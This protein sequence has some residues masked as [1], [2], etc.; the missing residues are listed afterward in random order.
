MC[1]MSRGRFNAL[2]KEAFALSWNFS[3]S[4]C[5][6]WEQPKVSEPITLPGD[7]STHLAP[8]DPSC[9]HLTDT[10]TTSAAGLGDKPA[11][12]TCSLYP[13]SPNPSG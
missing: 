12:R 9:S 1:I 2:S 7:R 10:S 13:I 11:P 4:C 3:A 8:P 5:F 6:L